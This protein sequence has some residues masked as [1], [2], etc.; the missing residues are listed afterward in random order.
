MLQTLRSVPA[1]ERISLTA[2]RVAEH[3]T[4]SAETTD[5][6]ESQGVLRAFMEREAVPVD[7]QHRVIF[8]KDWFIGIWMY[9]YVAIS[10]IRTIPRE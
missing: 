8:D 5:G 6:P 4:E 7:P 2:E 9:L 3:T 10:L 1:L